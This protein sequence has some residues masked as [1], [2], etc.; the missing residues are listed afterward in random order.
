M[1]TTR[2]KPAY[3]FEGIPHV[4]I[5]EA[6]FNAQLSDMLLA[7]AKAELERAKVS[8]E[9]ITVPGAL[10]IPAAILYSLRAL[11]FDAIRRRFD[12][13]VA[14]GAVIKGATR[15]DEIVGNISAQGLQTLALDH[16]LAIGNGILT[17]ETLAQAQERADPA[18][19]DRGGAAA[20]ACL[21][22]VELKHDFRLMSKRR[23]VGR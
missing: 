11:D 23:W 16:T 15:H 19:F 12:G 4:M 2:E 20:A 7:G 18:R 1:Q 13:Y 9:V 17:C 14:L 8:F 10:E 6:R 22:M 5:V 3:K 21:R